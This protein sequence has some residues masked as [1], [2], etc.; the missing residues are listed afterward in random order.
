MRKSSSA[1]VPLS[2]VRPRHRRCL[3]TC[4][5]P[6]LEPGAYSPPAKSSTRC[7]SA[8][9]FLARELPRSGSATQFL[10]DMFSI[11]LVA[12][13]PTQFS[14]PF[15]NSAQLQSL[16]KPTYIRDGTAHLPHPS[17]PRLASLPP[18]RPPRATPSPIRVHTGRNL[19]LLRR[20]LPRKQLMCPRGEAGF[21]NRRQ[22]RLALETIIRA[23]V[24][25]SMCS[26][27]RAETASAGK[28]A[29]V[30]QVDETSVEHKVP[31]DRDA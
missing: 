6:L 19:R 5:V 12:F 2:L 21:W 18:G 27:L 30:Q 10:R 29:V 9:V 23:E 16:G 28:D 22:I 1:T 8:L 11:S 17:E 7:S 4:N 3:A 13:H 24:S 25:R 14:I 31:R 20:K 15:L 26:L